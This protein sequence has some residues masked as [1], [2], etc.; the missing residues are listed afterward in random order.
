M[1]INDAT[2]VVGVTSRISRARF[3]DIPRARGSAAAIEGNAEEAWSA[4]A[5]PP[6]LR[7]VGRLVLVDPVEEGR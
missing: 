4:V 3:A 7:E 5:Q 2:M 6:V 1:T